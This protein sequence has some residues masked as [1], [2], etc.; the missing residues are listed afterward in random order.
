M[1]KEPFDFKKEM[2]MGQ[3]EI[4]KLKSGLKYLLLA[5]VLLALFVLRPWAIVE[6]GNAGVKVRLGEVQDGV[7]DD[8]IHFKM[9]LMEDIIQLDVRTLKLE[10]AAS[11]ASKDLQV[12]KTV[13][14]TNYR[15]DEA[16]VD[17]LFR[18]IGPTYREKI[19]D[20]A[21][22]EVVK[23]VSAK[24]TAEELITK[25]PEVK[26][27]IRKELT[28]RLSPFDIIVVDI[29]ITDFDFAK[30]FNDAIEAKQVAE[31]NVQKAERDLQRIEIE[32]KQQITQAQAEA[33]SLRLQKQQITPDLIKLRQIENERKAIEKWNGVL[34]KVTG[35]V[36]PF[37]DVDNIK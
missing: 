27:Q 20:P 16:S 9:P 2:G 25:R 37:I 31:Q 5:A 23:A 15:L 10:S 4:K 6:P 3:G 18:T 24:F 30:S 17:K 33:E 28:N 35:G 13:I 29:S 34:P 8:G 21:V 19:I 14:A 32:A 1:A 12:V 22:Q 36:T 7:L 11:A 26:D